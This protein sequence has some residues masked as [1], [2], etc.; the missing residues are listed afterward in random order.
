MEPSSAVRHI[1][2][3]GLDLIKRFEGVDLSPYPDVRGVWTIGYGHTHGVDETYPDITL[4]EAENLLQG[5][6][7]AA[8]G[9]VGKFITATLTDNQFAALVS[10]TYN[11]GTAPL[12]MHL[13]G[14]V[15]AGKMAEA[16]DEFLKWNHSGGKV[17]D[18]LTNRRDA[19]RALFLTA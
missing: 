5:D 12:L 3:A 1:N 8:E 17:Y 19:E 2:Q 7:R 16:A 13:G 11:C 18:G 10:L 15:N 9:Y 6:L 4:A 14:Y